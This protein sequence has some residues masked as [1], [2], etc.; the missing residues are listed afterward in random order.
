M[1]FTQVIH[2]FSHS[3]CTWFLYCDIWFFYMVM[4][5]LYTWW[6]THDSFSFM[7]LTKKILIWKNLY[8]FS[9]TCTGEQGGPRW[10][11]CVWQAVCVSFLAY[12]VWLLFL[13]L[14]ISNISTMLTYERQTLFNNKQSFEELSARD[15][16]GSHLC[17][18]HVLASILAYLWQK[19]CVLY[20]RK[21]DAEEDKESA[22]GWGGGVGGLRA[23]GGVGVYIL[24]SEVLLGRRFGESV[25]AGRVPLN[26]SRS[27]SFQQL[28]HVCKVGVN[29]QNL[30]PSCR[31]SQLENKTML[32]RMA[33]L[34]VR[35]LV[36]KTFTLNDFIS[37][38]GSD[39][40]CMTWPNAGGRKPVSPLSELVPF[41]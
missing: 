37:L 3:F 6:F 35:S 36:N 34:N 5:F 38:R 25:L 41:D 7:W 1:W 28:L 20:R 21:E 2:L 13:L 17:P 29:L 11:R 22:W 33:L 23:V 27:R 40:L 30:K 4:R 9:S 24:Q 18:P 39:F 12:L 8:L 32:I 19:L 14:F 15:W 10:R 26:F 31:A 16:R